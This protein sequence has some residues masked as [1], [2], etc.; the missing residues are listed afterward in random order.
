MPTNIAPKGAIWV[1]GACGK[2]AR[3]NYGEGEHTAGWDESCMMN[4]VLCDERSLM[5]GHDG[6]VFHAEP[7]EPQPDSA[8]EPFPE[9]SAG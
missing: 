3:D 2:T 7:F 8:P 5:R 9:G 4:A 1:C 6:R